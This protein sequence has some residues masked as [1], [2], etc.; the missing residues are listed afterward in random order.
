MRFKSPSV[1]IK[2]NTTTT[3]QPTDIH[4]MDIHMRESR[5][6]N[7]GSGHPTPAE[8]PQ[9]IGFASNTGPNPLKN[10]EATKLAVNVVPSFSDIWIPHQLKNIVKVGSPL[11]K[12][13]GSAHDPHDCKNTILRNTT[14]SLFLS[15]M[16]TKLE[17]KL[18]TL[19]QTK[20]QTPLHTLGGTSNNK[21]TTTESLPYL[22]DSI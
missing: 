21:S 8:K 16:I 20:D 11:K 12:L 22:T 19:S 10:H 1:Y 13:S 6:G 17:L 2:G 3:V 7:K 4:T 18:I 5:E 15:E 9:H 14:S